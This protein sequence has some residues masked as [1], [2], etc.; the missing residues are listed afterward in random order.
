M[1]PERERQIGSRLKAFREALQISRSKF[2]VSCGFGSERIAS[3]E[4]GR[5]PL[6]YAVFSAISN[7]Y[8][9]NPFW[10]VLGD[11]AGSPRLDRPFDDRPFVGSVPPRSLFSE[12]YDESLSDALGALRQSAQQDGERHKQRIRALKEHL[13]RQSSPPDQRTLDEIQE[14]KSF[15]DA[16]KKNVV[17]REKVKDH[18]DVENNDLTKRPSSPS[19]AGVQ[20]L[21]QSL[22]QRLQLA[23]SE[24]GKKSELAKFLKVDLSLVSRWLS[25]KKSAREPGAEYTLLMLHWVEHQKR[26]K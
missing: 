25:D 14:L 24:T 3:Y 7:R 21:W 10:L 1:I 17:F 23:T 19:I 9:V 2:S 11:E 18:M 22:K 20:N 26:Q 16:L 15:S 13:L 12:V 8:F 6:P 4:S 5:A